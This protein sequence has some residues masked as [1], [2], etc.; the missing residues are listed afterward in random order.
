MS[1]QNWNE[2]LKSYRKNHPEKTKQWRLNTIANELRKAGYSVDPPAS[3]PG[4]AS[5]R[6]GCNDGQASEQA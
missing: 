3:D 1:E 4:H 2:Y 6:N 5:D